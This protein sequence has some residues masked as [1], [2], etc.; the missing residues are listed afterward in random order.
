MNILGRPA[1]FFFFKGSRG[2]EDLEEREVT[3]VGIGRSGGR[4]T[5]D[6]INRKRIKG[7]RRN[8]KWGMEKINK[9]GNYKK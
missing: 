6:A 7:K 1:L 3:G 9:I 5:C 8:Y 4:G 2:G